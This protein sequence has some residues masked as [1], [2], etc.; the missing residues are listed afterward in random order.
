MPLQVGTSQVSDQPPLFRE[1]K[2]AG[3]SLGHPFLRG[4]GEPHGARSTRQMIT[5]GEP[6]QQ[7]C[8]S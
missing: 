5:Q 8:S 7:S 3:W 6:V 4:T 2:W 1:P